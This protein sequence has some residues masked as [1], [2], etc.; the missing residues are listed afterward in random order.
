MD[1]NVMISFPFTHALKQCWQ[2][3]LLYNEAAD[4]DSLKVLF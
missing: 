2:I 1:G 4:L 3:S